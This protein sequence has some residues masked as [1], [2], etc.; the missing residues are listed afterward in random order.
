MQELLCTLQW[1]TTKRRARFT[2]RFRLS[3]GGAEVVGDEDASGDESG[4]SGDIEYEEASG[5]GAGGADV[6]DRAASDQ[7]GSRV[8]TSSLS[9]TYDPWERTILSSACRPSNVGSWLERADDML[10][11]DSGRHA[12]DLDVEG[13]TSRPTNRLCNPYKQHTLRDNTVAVIKMQNPE[14]GLQA[15]QS[16]ARPRGEVIREALVV[17]DFES[18]ISLVL[19]R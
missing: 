15:I 14:T 12:D 1:L 9:S 11:Q 3:V 7:N 18:T 5:D 2:S 10:L 19:V 16:E 4:E 17:H 8:E 6:G 13:G